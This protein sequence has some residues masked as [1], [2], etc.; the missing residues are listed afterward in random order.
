M[1]LLL[2]LSELPISDSSVGTPL[3]KSLLFHP[4]V[5]EEAN[6]L[7]SMKDDALTRQLTTALEQTNAD[8]MYVDNRLEISRNSKTSTKQL[9]LTIIFH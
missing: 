4:R 7:L 5:A 2:V 1:F 6:H 3:K 9:F 8:H